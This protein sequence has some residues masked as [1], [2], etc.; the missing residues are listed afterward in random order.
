[1][2]KN[3]KRTAAAAIAAAMAMSFAACGEDTI[4]AATANGEQIPAGVYIYFL[5]NA[6]YDALYQQTADEDGNTPDLF[7]QQIDGMDA[8]DWIREQAAQ[9][10]LRISA[11][12]QKCGEYGIELSSDDE[13]AAKLYIE[14]VWD[15]YGSYYEDEGISMQSYLNIYE[16]NLKSQ[17]LFEKLYGEGGDY[18][19]SESELKAYLD[20]NY[21]LINYISMELKD[22]EGNLLK[23]AGKEERKAMAEEYIE[24]YKN[25]ESL[26]ALNAEYTAWYEEL[27]AEAEA[28]LAAAEAESA[29]NADNTLET[30]EVTASDAQASNNIED[31]EITEE[32]ADDIKEDGDHEPD[33]SIEMDETSEAPEESGTAEEQTDSTEISDEA[34]EI[35]SEAEALDSNLQ[36]I[37]KSG[38]TPA[39]SVVTAVFDEMEKGEIRLI[40]D[41][42]YY[43]IA[44][45][46]DVLETDEYYL[47]AKA[48]LLSEMK[49]DEYDEL[50]ESW[51]SEV[52]F[53]RNQKAFDRYDPEKIFKE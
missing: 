31:D 43:Y 22:G 9:E 5:Q 46:L 28:A 23:S 34:A 53:Q 3:I 27:I 10:M 39:Q 8:K 4:W 33:Q 32:P 19:V 49:S 18:E 20:E 40:E 48:S 2:R 30:A 26:D 24:R 47:T 50:V 51:K 42:E 17:L 35:N 25:G 36:V 16:N 14:Q 41:N 7:T 45:K 37:E 12:E 11:V 13:E 21:A 52:D 44:V 15:Y 38:T 1:M 29:E 6:Y